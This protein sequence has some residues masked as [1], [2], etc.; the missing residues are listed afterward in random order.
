M[1]PER[2][3]KDYIDAAN[4]NLVDRLGALGGAHVMLATAVCMPIPLIRLKT[5]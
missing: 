5:P 4:E 3:L 1:M 2:T